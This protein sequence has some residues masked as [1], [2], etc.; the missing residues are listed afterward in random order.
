MVPGQELHENRKASSNIESTGAY[1]DREGISTLC[2]R[3][4]WGSDLGGLFQIEEAR[5]VGDARQE[6]LFL[7][8]VVK[9]AIAD[10]FDWVPSIARRGFE[11]RPLQRLARG[12]DWPRLDL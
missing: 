4:K 3:R 12:R 9:V 7:Q 2:D 5:E 10:A 6:P 1:Q 8:G 11:L